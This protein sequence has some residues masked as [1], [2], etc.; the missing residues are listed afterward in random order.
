IRKCWL[1]VS[2]FFVAGIS[3]WT[4]QPYDNN[5]GSFGVLLLAQAISVA[6]PAT[7]KNDE[8]QQVPYNKNA[9]AADQAVPAPAT[10]TTAHRRSLYDE[11]STIPTTNFKQILNKAIKKGIGGGVPG[12]IAGVIQVLA[13]MWLRTIINHQ[14]RYGASFM[15]SIKLLYKDGG[16][17][18]FYAGLGFALLQAP[19]SRFVATA[20]NDGVL[21]LLANLSATK[22]W[23]PG[24][25]TFFAST[26]VGFF[27]ILLMPIDTFKTVSQVDG[28]EG[29]RMLMTRVRQGKIGV[30]YAG[31][32]ATAV[33]ATLGHYP[34]FAC[35]NVLKSASW[36]PVL[37]PSQLLR[38]A[39]IG[40]ISS[41]ISDT[42]V[43]VFRVVKTT[44][45][46]M[47]SKHDM[48]YAQTIRMILDA[49]GWKGLFGRGLRTRIL[50]NALQ[51]VLFTVI[52]R[53]LAERWGK[54]AGTD[55]D[56]ESKTGVRGANATQKGDA[57]NLR[58]DDMMDLPNHRVEH[59]RLNDT[60]R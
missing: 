4:Q 29:F 23:G 10:A 7:Q 50:A 26:F 39:T 14:S 11:S 37:I 1:V 47:G 57:P 3:S 60:V 8:Q 35:Y 56:A 24:I 2:V 53:G 51:S 52:W 9:T 58:V 17:P 55:A 46:S 38:N 18:R 13:L 34:W 40:L 36:L 41:I 30:L 33:S 48:S 54:D 49:D 44:K 12:A 43:N 6:V 42:F 19:I 45:Q 21:M 27:R 20:S 5:G 16:F 15:Q 31:S 25:T 28:R 32:I 59:R 22:H